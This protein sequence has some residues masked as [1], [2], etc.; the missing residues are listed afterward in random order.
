[1][2]VT[3]YGIRNC[4]TMK[5]TFA[6]LDG[7]GVSYDFHDYKRKGVPAGKLA[8]WEEVAGWERLVNTRGTTWRRIPEVDRQDLDASRAL[9]LLAK[10]PSAIKRP[11][12]EAGKKLLVGFDAE[13]FERQFV[14]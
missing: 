1:M 2:K 7:H 8:A 4:D 5:K 10:Y 3:V 11:V 14:Q 9:A 13:A 6:W 12:V